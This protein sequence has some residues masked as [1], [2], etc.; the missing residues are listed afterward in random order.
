MKMPS[1]MATEST[2]FH[3]N[4]G[5]V[6]PPTDADMAVATPVPT[7]VP[8]KPS[9]RKKSPPPVP[10]PDPDLTALPDHHERVAVVVEEVEPVIIET[11]SVVLPF[12]SGDDSGD[13]VK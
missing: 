9:A 1:T 5:F 6:P 4:P 8:K 2:Y 12:D 7:D 3:D 11:G 10:A 13:T